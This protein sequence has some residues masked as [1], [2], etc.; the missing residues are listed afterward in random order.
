M[1]EGRR[2][3]RATSGRPDGEFGLYYKS[4][5]IHLLR[6]LPGFSSKEY[7]FGPV[8]SVV[9]AH[10]SFGCT[11]QRQIRHRLTASV[12]MHREMAM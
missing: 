11:T 5:G 7:H 6:L 3:G 4:L 9:Q 10:I 12:G 1:R 2:N 8:G